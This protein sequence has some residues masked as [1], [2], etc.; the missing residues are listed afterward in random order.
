MNQK[1]MEVYAE[2]RALAIAEPQS[3][4]QA[5]IDGMSDAMARLKKELSDKD[6]AFLSALALAD[7]KRLDAE[8][9]ASCNKII[10]SVIYEPNACELENNALK[11]AAE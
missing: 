11:R 10:A 4:M 3:A 1:Q 7:P 8:A 2:V 9:K 5:V 6:R